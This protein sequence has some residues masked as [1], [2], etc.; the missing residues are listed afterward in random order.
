MAARWPNHQVD[1][2]AG[3]QPHLLPARVRRPP[4]TCSSSRQATLIPTTMKSPSIPRTWV[5]FYLF[6]RG[7]KGLKGARNP[8]ARAFRRAHPTVSDQVRA[9]A[10]QPS[11]GCARRGPV[12]WGTADRFPPAHSRTTA[13]PCVVAFCP[14]LLLLAGLGIARVALLFTRGVLLRTWP[15][16]RGVIRR[17]FPGKPLILKAPECYSI[18]TAH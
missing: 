6:W 15:V 4:A 5:L 14:L 9:R 1:H 16:I 10:A 7:V 8:P 11:R 17:E 13:L 18:K 2:P 3:F 12:S